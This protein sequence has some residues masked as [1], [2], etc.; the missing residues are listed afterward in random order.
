[1]AISFRSTPTLTLAGH[2]PGIQ[3]LVYPAAFFRATSVVDGR[4]FILGEKLTRYSDGRY[5]PYLDTAQ[6]S[7]EGELGML[8]RAEVKFYIDTDQ[9]FESYTAAFLV[10]NQKV[11][12][13]YGWRN[14]HPGWGTNGQRN[15]LSDMVI[16]DFSF[17][18]VGDSQR[19]ACTFKA[20]A[21]TTTI[22]EVEFAVQLPQDK[23]SNYSFITEN[24][25]GSDKENPVTSMTELILAQA[26]TR[27]ADPGDVPTQPVVY[28]APAENAYVI[29]TRFMG[30]QDDNSAAGANVRIYVNL[31]YIV[32]YILNEF[33]LPY[34][35]S[36]SVYDA[37][38][39]QYK[40]QQSIDISGV[41]LL[42]SP[43]PLEVVFP[44]D[45]AASSYK[46][47][48]PAL[49]A[50]YTEAFNGVSFTNAFVDGFSPCI[51]GTTLTLGNIL[52]SLDAL[53]DIQKQVADIKDQKS[54][55]ETVD[56]SSRSNILLSVKDFIKKIS[57]LINRNSGGLIDLVAYHP[58]VIN[59][60]T[61]NVID[62]VDKN[63]KNVQGATPLIFN[64]RFPGDGVTL[65]ANIKAEVPKDA[66]AMNAYLNNIKGIS[67]DVVKN[68][69]AGITEARRQRALKW[70]ESELKFRR[71]DMFTALVKNG[72][73]EETRETAARFVR[74]YVQ[75][76]PL[77]A[78]YKHG[79]SPYP[80]KLTLSI[81]GVHGFK[82]GD[83][84]TLKYMP[85]Q[86]Q[87]DVCFRVIR[88]THKFE[89]MNWITD[90]ETVC[91][92]K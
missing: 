15:T 21:A 37:Q 25:I 36:T 3:G 16:Y 83:L 60:D 47:I 14:P 64:N 79:N 22:D 44:G 23:V 24:W 29:V 65:V 82:F 81:V 26:Q 2:K 92:L 40:L 56:E 72:F 58:E 53:I 68:G 91:D 20:M 57:A 86:Y 10:P 52:I 34:H 30:I 7:V 28:K 89:G 4:T 6:I 51:S 74:Q 71:R 63:F 17:E 11:T 73:N 38:P 33:I 31:D 19:Y 48:D 55:A 8:T 32:N 5:A 80:L 87:Q 78:V 54:K 27:I 9:D 59:G 76:R 46:I 41:P 39:I 43:N 88:Q 13:E 42:F 1:M 77:A 69:K 18:Y 49:Q 45:D 50:N 75:N 67:A 12:L 70:A 66:I 35:I 90:L 85:K 61:S 62:I 84:I